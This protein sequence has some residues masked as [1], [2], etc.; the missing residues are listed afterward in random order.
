MDN[1]FSYEVFDRQ[2]WNFIHMWEVMGDA[3]QDY[4]TQEMTLDILSL[5]TKAGRLCLMADEDMARQNNDLIH[6]RKMQNMQFCNSMGRLVLDIAFPLMKDASDRLNSTGALEGKK[7]PKVP[8]AF[9]N[10]LPTLAEMADPDTGQQLRDISQE[11]EMMVQLMNERGVNTK[12][13]GMTSEDRMLNLFI[14]FIRTIYLSVHFHK[15]Q[16]L[17]GTQLN[18]EEAARLLESTIQGYLD[19]PEGHD[20][21]HLFF[22]T[23]RYDNDGQDPTTEQLREA[24]RQLRKEV[25]AQYLSAF[26]DHAGDLT[27]LAQDFQ[28]MDSHNDEDYRRLLSAEAKWLLIEHEINI[29][30][31]PENIITSLHNQVFHQA[32]LGRPVDMQRLRDCIANMATAITKKYHWFSLWC[33]LKHHNLLADTT[34]EFFAQQMMHP[35]WFGDIEPNK[36]FTG[37]TLREYTGYFTQFDYSVWNSASFRHYRDLHNK[38][39]WADA[40]CDGL[41]R[42][43]LEME[44]LFLPL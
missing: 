6:S 19:S 20:D 29:R 42:K 28:G 7:W 34:L 26:L 12:L 18:N 14:L 36:R 2:M 13:H 35:D 27:A 3:W 31:H 11:A 32:V 38:K 44:E 25:P 33:V 40:L 5:S 37:D 22:S 24:R 23:L 41:L 10:T 17:C 1:E 43:C 4:G 30:E 39:K 16:E 21:M 9:T 8:T 15:T